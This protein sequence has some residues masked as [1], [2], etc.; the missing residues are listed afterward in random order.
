MLFSYKVYF[1]AKYDRE[2]VQL[3]KYLLFKHKFLCLTFRD[4]VKMPSVVVPALRR[5]RQVGPE[6]HQPVRPVKDCLNKV[7]GT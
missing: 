1:L 5:Q 4:N 6:A 3:V 2:I 7:D